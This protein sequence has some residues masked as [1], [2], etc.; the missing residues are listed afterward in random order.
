VLVF[1]LLSWSLTLV[2]MTVIGDSWAIAR[3]SLERGE[4]ARWQ[5]TATPGVSERRGT[6]KWLLAYVD[7]AETRD[8]QGVRQFTHV[9]MRSRWGMAVQTYVVGCFVLSFG[10]VVWRRFIGC[11]LA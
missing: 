6:V 3:G 9:K 5:A 2:A 8:E 7:Y 11:L 4:G 10:Y 1:V